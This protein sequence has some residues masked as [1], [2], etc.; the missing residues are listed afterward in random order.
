MD[1]GK[2]ALE[3]WGRFPGGASGHRRAPASFPSWGWVNRRD[4]ILI[5]ACLPPHP[6]P[7]KEFN[8]LPPPSLLLFFLFLSAAME[9]ICYKPTQT[10]WQPKIFWPFPRQTRRKGVSHWVWKDPARKML[11]M[12][13]QTSLLKE[14][15]KGF[16]KVHRGGFPEGQAWPGIRSGKVLLGEVGSCRAD[17]SLP[18]NRVQPT[19]AP[20]P[21]G[22]AGTT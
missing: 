6:G 16:L 20:K 9:S 14:K 7:C 4:V 12:N 18:L 21:R 2:S 17:L 19:D 13:P 15:S 22:N 3:D 8:S 11:W 10:S 5:Q 1:T